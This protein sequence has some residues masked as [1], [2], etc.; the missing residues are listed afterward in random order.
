MLFLVRDFAIRT[1]SGAAD[2][3][4]VIILPPSSLILSISW[5][6]LVKLPCPVLV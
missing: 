6:G 5:E 3:F 1:N 2:R 4:P